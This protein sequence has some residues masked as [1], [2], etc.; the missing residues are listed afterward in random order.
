MNAMVGAG[1]LRHPNDRQR[2]RTHP[3]PKPR[4][5]PEPGTVRQF[6]RIANDVPAKPAPDPTTHLEQHDPLHQ[7]LFSGILENPFSDTEFAE[8]GHDAHRATRNRWIK[9]IETV[10][11]SWGEAARAYVLEPKASMARESELAV[12]EQMDKRYSLAIGFRDLLGTIADQN[13]TSPPNRAPDRIYRLP[14][15][16]ELVS[17]LSLRMTPRDNADLSGGQMRAVLEA[18]APL[19][20]FLEEVELDRI[21]RCAHEKC[22]KIFWAGRVDRPCCSDACRNAYKQKTHRERKKQNRPYKKRMQL[23]K[24]GTTK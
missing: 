4:A 8:S 1:A 22:G 3:K 16:S 11:E 21:K 13:P 20:S 19:K 17:V 7:R 5:R 18:S 23:R 6:I 9:E 15:S 2:L 10:V 12:F 24:R 14:S